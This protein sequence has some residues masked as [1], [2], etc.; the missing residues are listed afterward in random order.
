[1]NP[2]ELINDLKSRINPAYSFQSGTESYERRLCVE[3]IESL[4]AERDMLKLLRDINLNEF[5]DRAGC[6]V[7]ECNPE[8]WGGRYAYAQKDRPLSKVSGF[9]TR[10]DAT[11]YWLK[12]TFGIPAANAILDLINSAV[13]ATGHDEKLKEAAKSALH[14]MRLHKYAD[15]AWA[16]DLEAA[17]RGCDT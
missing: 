14:Y 7:I 8:V 3:A 2:R 4:I 12:D 1:M 16:D 10:E 13:N 11:R 6:L 5:A 15:Q 17:I 9:E